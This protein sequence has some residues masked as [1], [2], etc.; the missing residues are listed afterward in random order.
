VSEFDVERD[1]LDHLADGFRAG[2]PHHPS[3]LNE[4]VFLPRP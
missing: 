3:Y 4:F 2:R 1:Q